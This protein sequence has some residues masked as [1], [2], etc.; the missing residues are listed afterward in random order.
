VTFAVTNGGGVVAPTTPVSTNS[1][2]IATATSWIVGA[3]DGTNNNT[4]LA[5]STGLSGSPVS[6]TASGTT[7]T[8]VVITSQPTTATSGAAMGTV[9]VRLKDGADGNVTQPNIPITASLQSGSG[10][11]SG[12]LSVITTGQGISNFTNLI[13]TGSGSFTLRFVAGNLTPAVS[14][15]IT[16]P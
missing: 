14:T 8:K 15:S 3:S 10:N 4:V 6:F 2:G 1:S 13:Y 16:I 5:T 12:T 11:L 9:S 7:A